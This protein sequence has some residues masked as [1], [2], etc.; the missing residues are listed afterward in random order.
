MGNILIKNK[1]FFCKLNKI[2]PEPLALTTSTS[3]TD[4]IGSIS[5]QKNN[6]VDQDQ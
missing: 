1:W 6:N 5:P 4:S 2:T 3:F